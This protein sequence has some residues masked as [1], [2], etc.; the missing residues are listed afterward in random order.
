MS[1]KSAFAGDDKAKKY[2]VWLKETVNLLAGGLVS[3]QS[4]FRDKSN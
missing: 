4:D 2:S 1:N 3:N